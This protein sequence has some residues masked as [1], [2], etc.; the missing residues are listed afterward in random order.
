MFNVLGQ[1]ESKNN[2]K[3]TLNYLTYSLPGCI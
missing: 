1:F 2:G 3:L